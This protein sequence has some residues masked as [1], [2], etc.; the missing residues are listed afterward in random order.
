MK[1]PPE[2]VCLF[3]NPDQLSALVCMAGFRSGDRLETIA[4]FGA[5][6][7][8]LMYSLDQAKKDNPK[9]V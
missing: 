3:V 7:H 8:S 1:N 5:A 2:L 9:M 4:P 6:C